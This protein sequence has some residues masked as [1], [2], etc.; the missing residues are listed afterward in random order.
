MNSLATS[1]TSPLTTIKK[2]IT[3]VLLTVLQSSNKNEIGNKK[4]TLTESTR[5]LIKNGQDY[6]Q[7]LLGNTT[8]KTVIGEQPFGQG[9]DRLLLHGFHV[10]DIAT[11][12]ESKLNTHIL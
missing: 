7:I 8:Q 12:L 6:S 2:M 5:N 10:K 1:I 4:H 11:D 9:H 3:E